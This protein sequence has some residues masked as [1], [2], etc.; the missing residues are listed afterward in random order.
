MPTWV[1]R[2][3]C[4]GFRCAGR[5]LDIGTPEAYASAEQ[6]FLPTVAA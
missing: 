3:G 5:F 2:Y 6:F 4:Y 1:E